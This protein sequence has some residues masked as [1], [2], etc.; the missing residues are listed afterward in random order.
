M[1]KWLEIEC[2]L[3]AI[4]LISYTRVPLRLWFDYSSEYSAQ[5]S[6][7]LPAIGLVVGSVGAIVFLTANRF[8]SPTIALLFSM[9]AT[10]WITGAFHE[11]GFADVCDGFGGG[12][13]RDRILE[14][15]KDPRVGSF[16]AIGITLLLLVKF[17]ALHELSLSIPQ[18]LIIGHAISRLAAISF[19]RIHDYVATAESKVSALAQR[20]SWQS[21]GIGIVTVGAAML[22]SGSVAVWLAVIPVVI[23]CWLL[24]RLFVRKLGGYTGDC[25]GAAQQ[26]SEAVYYLGLGLFTG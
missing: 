18:A 21:L 16:G 13:N 2:R 15:M 26:V 7:Y 9:V 25:L 3:F 5:A 8:F 23:A 14:I 20:L 11:D 22:L 6:R 19:M 17:S 4:A 12:W 10:V 24:G 1:P